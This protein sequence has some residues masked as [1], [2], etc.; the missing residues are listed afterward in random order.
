MRERKREIIP[1][2]NTERIK[3]ERRKSRYLNDEKVNVSKKKRQREK[4]IERDVD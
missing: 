1:K 4:E 3:G 2:H